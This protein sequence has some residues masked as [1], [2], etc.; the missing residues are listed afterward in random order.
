[1][2]PDFSVEKSAPADGQGPRGKTRLEFSRLCGVIPNF[3]GIK[4]CK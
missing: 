4:M 3:S 1:M 2:I